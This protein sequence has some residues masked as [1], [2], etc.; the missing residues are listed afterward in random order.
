[1]DGNNDF[2]CS[3]EKPKSI[4]KSTLIYSIFTIPLLTGFTL[5]DKVLDSS[6]AENRGVV[7]GYTQKPETNNTTTQETSNDPS[8]PR[9]KTSEEY[10]AE[11][12]ELSPEI[13]HYT[14]EEM[15]TV[16]DMMM[17]L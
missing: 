15:L 14:V 13:K 12:D 9:D 4:W 6:V 17:I 3:H 11:I 16:E 10:L 5:P 1:M 7:L 8:P 2:E